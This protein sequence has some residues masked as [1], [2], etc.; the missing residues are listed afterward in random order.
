M[1]TLK[2][3]MKLKRGDVVLF[4]ARKTARVVQ[5]GPANYE[6]AVVPYVVFAIMRRSWTNRIVTYYNFTDGKHLLFLPPKR[7]KTSVIQAE[8]E[9][10]LADI[11]FDV[12]KE[13]RRELKEFRAS[14]KRMERCRPK[15]KFK[16]T[17]GYNWRL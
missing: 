11:G 2:Q 7:L 3:F 6:G 17:P 13:K 12:D 10:T 16:C 9:Q 1:I 14:Q 4:G 8:N 15:V 5:K